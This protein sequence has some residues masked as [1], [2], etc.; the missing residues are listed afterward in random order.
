[1]EF[2]Q[3]SELDWVDIYI[4][5]PLPGSELYEI[6]FKGGYL[7]NNVLDSCD[8]WCGNIETEF[9]DAAQ[10]EN[11]QLYNMLKKDFVNSLDMKNKRW[12][13]ALANFEYVINAG[14]SNP[15]A[16]YYATSAAMKLGDGKKADRYYKEYMYIR[17]E[18]DKWEDLFQKFSDESESF[19]S[20]M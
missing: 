10:I 9:F 6:C 4:A 11:I 15:F 14:H 8:Y 2:I 1:M 17:E 16:Y 5:S 13:R 7:K 19:P 12:E 20:I 18:S 3:E